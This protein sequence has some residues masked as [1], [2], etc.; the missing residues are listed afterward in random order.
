MEEEF[1][2]QKII[3]KTDEIDQWAEDAGHLVGEITSFLKQLNHAGAE[4]TAAEKEC[5][6][7]VKTT[8][9]AAEYLN[10][11]NET[12]KQVR[13]KAGAENTISSKGFHNSNTNSL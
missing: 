6:D 4:R 11:V 5:T 12:M 1:M 10:E 3:A 7:A 8:Q 2:K 9:D 13:E